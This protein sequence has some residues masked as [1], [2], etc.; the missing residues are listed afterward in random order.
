MGQGVLVAQ[1]VAEVLRIDPGMESWE[2]LARQKLLTP[3]PQ[4]GQF[5]I[6][7]LGL[8]R[9]ASEARHQ[10]GSFLEQQ[11]ILVL[12]VQGLLAL[13]TKLMQ[14]LHIARHGEAGGCAL[15]PVDAELVSERWIVQQVQGLFGQVARIQ[16]AS[17]AVACE[18]GI[19]LHPRCRARGL[20]KA[21]HRHAFAE[22]VDGHIGQGI[23]P[24]GE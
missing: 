7:W 20:L 23:Q 10:D 13:G 19:V 6:G 21:Q 17:Q 4:V 16:V 18:Q 2:R 24:G 12:L 5:Q 14:G 1:G 11:A 3:R 8:A 9:V 15:L 22:G